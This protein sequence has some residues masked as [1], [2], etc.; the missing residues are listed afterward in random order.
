MKE[1]IKL[2][3]MDC[4]AGKW[5]AE[6]QAKSKDIHDEA[7]LYL[8]FVEGCGYTVFDLTPDEGRELAKILI[9]K[10]DEA[11]KEFKK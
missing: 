3:Q 10:A 5:R 6:V 1:S 2:S 7:G 4:Y 11:E 9:Q 8:Q